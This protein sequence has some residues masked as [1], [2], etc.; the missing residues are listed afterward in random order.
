MTTRELLARRRDEVI[1]AAARRRASNLR[2]FGPVARGTDRPESDI[3]FFVDLDPQG[4]ALDLIEL[5]EEIKALPGRS[6]DVLTP[7]SI[8]PFLKERILAEAQPLRAAIP[9]HLNHVRLSIERI[10]DD[11]HDGRSASFADTHTQYAVVRNL[12]IIGQTVRDPGVDDPRAA[13]PGVPWRGI[14]GLRNVLAHQYLGV[15]LNVVWTVV[16]RELPRLRPGVDA[17]LAGPGA[18]GLDGSDAS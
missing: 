15:D 9:P 5:K 1:A 14:A 11:T 13:E 6:A 7:D 16:E 10:L 17:L 4:S 18:A 2:V 12:E 3:D 8:S